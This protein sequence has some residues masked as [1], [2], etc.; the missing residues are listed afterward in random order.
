MRRVAECA[1]EVAMRSRLLLLAPVVCGLIALSLV[2]WDRPLQA[3]QRPDEV[4]L[5]GTVSAQDEGPLEGVLISAKKNGSTITTTVV[6]DS[7]GRYRFPRAR[8][9]PG[10]YALRIRA[11]GYDVD[12]APTPTV[13]AGKTATVDLK[14]KK[15]RDV[16]AQLSNAEWLASFPGTDE[17]KASIRGCTHCHTLER[18]ARTKYTA[19]QLVTVIERM[20]TYPQLSFPMKI[21]KLVAPRIGGG[22]ISPEQQRAAWQRQADYLA[23][24]NLST[25]TQWSYPFKILPRPT[26]AATQVIYTEYDL[27]Q[28]TRQP[29]DVIVDSTGAAWYASFGE[30]ILGKLDPATGTVT[31]Y[32]VPL[33][34]PTAPTGILGMRFDGDQNLWMALQFQGGIAKFD[35]KS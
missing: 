10:Q 8:L 14:L 33:L 31:E 15:A 34:K 26:G 1:P 17:Q 28:R 23:T 13:A 29:H 18:I 35:K 5:T 32:P 3:Q 21:Q 27:P 25:A 11:T 12:P 6:S 19:D 9:E 30:Q 7:S 2:S 22:S 4:A 16:A 24:I 20:S